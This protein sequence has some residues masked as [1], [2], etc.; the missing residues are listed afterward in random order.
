MPHLLHIDSSIQGDR[1]VSR[2]LT[3][4]AAAAWRAAH[5]AA[6]SPTAT[7][8]ASRCRTSTRTGGLAR[9]VP[10]GPAHAGAGRVLGADPASSSTRSRRPTPSCSA[11][12]STTSA[13]PAAS[14][15][16]STTSS[17]PACR[18]TR[19]P[20][21]ACSA[22]ATSSCSPPAAAAT[23][24][25]RPAKA[26]TTPSRGCRTAS[27]MT[28]LEPRFITAELTLAKVNP[29]MAELIP[30]A[31]KSLAAA[32]QAIDE[33]WPRH[34]HWHRVSTQPVPRC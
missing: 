13:R 19:R 8:A 29:A 22:A 15:P 24:P 20:T 11:C 27:S 17:P 18:S 4:R 25:A 9:M 2:R 23:A 1:S 7:W 30:L 10:R 34:P 28:G 26:G 31:D 5:P 33:L 14:S 21:R 6:P 3:A 16:G 32:E 12:R